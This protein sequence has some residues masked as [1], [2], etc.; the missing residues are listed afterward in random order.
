MEKINEIGNFKF[1]VEPS[2][3]LFNELGNNNYDF[4]ELLS[5]LIDN[6]IA[7]RL[8]NQLLKVEIE[9]GHSSNNY[10]S[11]VL[12]KDNATGI[13]EKNLGNAVSPAAFSGGGGINEHG[14][15]MKQAIASLGKLDYL[16]TK[17]LIEDNT[18][19]IKEFKYGDI[20]GKIIENIFS[21]GTI[22]K[23]NNVKPIVQFAQ[24]AYTMGIVPKLGAKYRR[25]LKEDNQLMELEIRLVNLDEY[26]DGNPTV[27]YENKVYPV[28]PIYFHP[29]KRTNKPVIEN[30]IFKGMGWEAKFTFGYAPTDF[31]YEE[32]GIEKPK[33]YH[34]YYV[35]LNKQG[36]DLIEFDR[37]INFAQLSSIGIVKNP[38][39]DF[40]YIRGEIELI[41]GF[42]TS[43]T[44]NFFI[45]NENFTQLVNEIQEFL[46]DK[47]L[48]E[49]KN[50]PDEIPEA[51]LRGRLKSYL[52]NNPIVQKKKVVEEV[53]VGNL[54]GY[55]DILA[56]DEVWE[57][58]KGQC[59]GLDVYQL[60]AYL[61]MGGYNKGYLLAKT[62]T[63]GAREAAEFINKKHDVNITLASLD[64]F[65]ILSPATLEERKKYYN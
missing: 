32:L 29:N 37:V 24:Q 16:I 62:F 61:D 21:H 20:D 46:K 8:E 63:S 53:S 30:K 23:V 64:N 50:D 15:G 42:N 5:E 60:F 13:P 36:F 14:L 54:N 49:R 38:H 47:G 3:N 9:I 33:N 27:I 48:L 6:S 57:L 56:D 31:E 25:F 41:K 40:N 2:D 51:L 58:K 17:N 22:I 39:N 19:L 35:S 45:R 59:A 28:K 55:I 12:I 7:A 52:E 26:E 43:T 1:R 10:D 11:Y 18:Y 34:P 44:K 65:P 4:V